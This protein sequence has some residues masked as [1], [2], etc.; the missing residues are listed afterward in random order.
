MTATSVPTQLGGWLCKGRFVI[1]IRRHKTIIIIL[2]YMLCLFPIYIERKQTP[3][4]SPAT[5]NHS[6]Y[7]YTLY[8]YSIYNY[9]YRR[10]TKGS[11]LAITTYNFV[12][13]CMLRVSF[14]GG[15]HTEIYRNIQKCTEM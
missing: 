12:K 14:Q 1:Y 3:S 8:I 2:N 15:T 4:K 5:N 7:T 10:I 13:L 9:T 11:I 6:L